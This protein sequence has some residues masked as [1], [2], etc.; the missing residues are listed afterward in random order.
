MTD[1][2]DD[3]KKCT[4]LLWHDAKTAKR[5]GFEKVAY[6]PETVQAVSDTL[7][8]AVAE[9]TRLRGEVEEFEMSFELR[10]NASRRGGKKWQEAGPGRELTWPDHADLVV[11]LM[12][13]ID[14]KD[15]LLKET[16]GA[17]RMA[18]E[19]G[20]GCGMLECDELT[21]DATLL[22]K[23]RDIWPVS[24]ARSLLTRMETNH[25]QD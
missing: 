9:I 2:L 22:Q 12:E 4:D 19:E 23:A 17:I 10:W 11:F 8:D 15:A 14:A 18:F 3:I 1:V 16:L 24:E 6:T 21:P 25:G 7:A 20:F 13:Q 5:N